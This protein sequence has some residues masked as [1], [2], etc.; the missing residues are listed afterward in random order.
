MMRRMVAGT[1]R[2]VG[3]VLDAVASA[4]SHGGGCR[5]DEQ[6]AERDGV[7]GVSVFLRRP[8]GWTSSGEGDA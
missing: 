3:N 4:A 1:C 6:G 7:G 8:V 2:G 5:D